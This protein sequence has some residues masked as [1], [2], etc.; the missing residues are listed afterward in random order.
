M[1]LTVLHKVLG[2][3]VLLLFSFSCASDLDFD[4]VNDLKLEPVVV[5]NL[6]YFNVEAKD[7]S[8][9][10]GQTVLIEQTTTDIFNDSFFR[11]RINRVELLF[12]L[13][14]TI[15][16]PYEV[17]LLFL[18]IDNVPIHITNLNIQSYSGTENKKSKTEVFEGVGLDILKKTTKIVFSL[19]MLAG[20][21][22]TPS[23]LGSL[24]FRSAATAEIIVK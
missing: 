3:A 9:G 1:K 17:I 18:N 24:K 13:E 11:R 8:S 12:E 5:A 6:A 2:I 15:N 14:N 4:Q 23:S 16:R 22:L 10:S 19:R 7:F 20:A 21:P